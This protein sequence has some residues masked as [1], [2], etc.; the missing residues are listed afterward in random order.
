MCIT[1]WGLMCKQRSCPRPAPPDL[2]DRLGS[3]VVCDVRDGLWE[4]PL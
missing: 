4:W 3:L 1:C 2:A